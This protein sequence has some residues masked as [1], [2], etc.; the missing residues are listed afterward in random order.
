MQKALAIAGVTVIDLPKGY[1]EKAEAARR[2]AGGICGLDA[3]GLRRWENLPRYF[4]IG[5]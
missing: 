5:L 3:G 2:T 4:T 1:R